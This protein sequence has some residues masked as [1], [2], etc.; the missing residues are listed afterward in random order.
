M[1][2]ASQANAFHWRN[3]INDQVDSQFTSDAYC[4]TPIFAKWRGLTDSTKE[5]TPWP[6]YR[7]AAIKRGEAIAARRIKPGAGSAICTLGPLS[8]K[9]RK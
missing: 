1:I 2:S 5:K 8:K 9:G 4:R 6:E 3:R 7:D